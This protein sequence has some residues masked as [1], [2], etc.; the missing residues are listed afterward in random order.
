MR[1]TRI[2]GWVPK[3]SGFWMVLCHEGELRKREDLSEPI[4][5][6]G[7]LPGDRIRDTYLFLKKNSVP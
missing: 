2:D 3:S 5:D 6:I 4:Q 7:V 1:S